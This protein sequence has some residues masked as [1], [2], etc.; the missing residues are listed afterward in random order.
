MSKKAATVGA[1]LEVR[2][3]DTYEYLR[4]L[5]RHPGPF[6]VDSLAVLN[7]PSGVKIPVERLGDLRVRYFTT[8]TIKHLVNTPGVTLLNDHSLTRYQGYYTRPL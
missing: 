7:N 1:F 6:P 8:G 3:E 5:G 4:Y 2:T